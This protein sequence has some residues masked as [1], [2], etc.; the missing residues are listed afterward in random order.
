MGM[1]DKNS[2]DGAGMGTETAVTIGDGYFQAGCCFFV[3]SL[4]KFRALCWNCTEGGWLSDRRT[5]RNIGGAVVAAGSCL[6]RGAGVLGAGT[7]LRTRGG[8]RPPRRGETG[9]S[10]RPHFECL[11]AGTGGTAATDWHPPLWC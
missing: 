4:R 3:V 10:W 6:E 8:M 5:E 1:G 7:G 2:G 11:G 9:D